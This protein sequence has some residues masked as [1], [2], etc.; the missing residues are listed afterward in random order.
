MIF[1]IVTNN[2]NLQKFKEIGEVN[3]L[4]QLKEFDMFDINVI[5]ISYELIWRNDNNNNNSINDISDFY[6]INRMLS[7]S[8]K[9]KVLFVFPQNCNYQFYKPSIANAKYK[10]TKQLKDMIPTVTDSI[11][12]H[13]IDI[14]KVLKLIYGNSETELSGI[15]YKSAFI[16]NRIDTAYAINSVTT[17]SGKA[18][19]ISKD[20]VYITTLDI[21]S[22]VS[23]FIFYLKGIG[24]YKE[25]QEPY[26]EWLE[27]YQILDDKTQTELIEEHRVKI[28]ELKQEIDF[29]NEKLEEN[30][31]FKSILYTNGDQLVEQVFRILEK[32]LDCNL[33]GFIDEKNEDFLIRFQDVSFIGEIKGVTSN[34]KSEHISQLDVHYQGYMDKL[35]ESGA[36]ENVKEIL[37]MNPFRNKPLDARTEVHENQKKLAERNDCL[38]IETITLLNLFE[39][40]MNKEISSS[41]VKDVFRNKKGLLSINDFD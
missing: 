4:N 38:V 31:K 21:L 34:I 6:S 12:V 1:Q 18:T 5:D 16:I 36:T 40:V 37:I 39:K 23:S 28:A 33:A 19:T 25:E 3:S 24:L 14:S 10:Y 29:A 2:L 11:I 7:Y 41:K 27:S 17:G 20:N 15:K 13:L 22:D 30:K 26:P 9:S 35:Q 8:Q 32:V